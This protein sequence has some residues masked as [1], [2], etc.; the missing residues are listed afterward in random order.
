MNNIQEINSDDFKT[1]GHE[2]IVK[3]GVN[4][5]CISCKTVF[6]VSEIKHWMKEA[7]V[8]ER[9]A[10]C[11]YCNVDTVVPELEGVT[12]TKEVLQEIAHQEWSF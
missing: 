6:P 8:E 9:T 3:Q 12:L 4:C 1:M 7:Y 10:W 11:P 5:G 2:S